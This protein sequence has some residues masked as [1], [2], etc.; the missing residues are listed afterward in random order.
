[1]Q[2]QQI[3]APK[4]EGCARYAVAAI[5]TILLTPTIVGIVLALAVA[6]PTALFAAIFFGA[7]VATPLV[8]IGA[9]LHAAL[10]RRVQ[11]R[12]WHSALAGFMLMLVI[13]ALLTAPTW[14]APE[15]GYWSVVMFL[16][17]GAIG[18]LIFHYFV[19]PRKAKADSNSE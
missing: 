8:L 7:I 14:T 3:A 4:G 17:L 5:A 1:M 11:L 9:G 19:T 15:D 13:V 12:W 16:G 2:D 6:D 18:G 10:A